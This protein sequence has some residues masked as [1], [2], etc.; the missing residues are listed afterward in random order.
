[1]RYEAI[2]QLTAY[3]NG[4]SYS[5]HGNGWRKTLVRRVEAGVPSFKAYQEAAIVPLYLRH[6]AM[7]VLSKPVAAG[8]AERNW[9]D[10]KTIWGKNKAV[11]TTDMVVKRHMVYSYAHRSPLFAS[12]KF[13]DNVG[14][15]NARI[16]DE[17]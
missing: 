17:E 7:V 10:T 14:K 6:I 2:S 15:V 13:F 1:M 3:L 9:A 8:V 16:L 12:R 11:M 4:E 5:N